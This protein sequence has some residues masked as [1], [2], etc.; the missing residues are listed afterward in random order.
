MSAREPRPTT[1]AAHGGP[2]RHHRQVAPAV[3]ELDEG[4]ARGLGVLQAHSLARALG[5]GRAV[6]QGVAHGALI[7]DDAADVRNGTGSDGE[8]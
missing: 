6:Y 2:E 4:Q 8:Y 3:P 5:P 7:L 1:R